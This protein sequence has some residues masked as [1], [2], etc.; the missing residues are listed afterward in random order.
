MN[1]FILLLYVMGWLLF[2]DL[3]TSSYVFNNGASTV[4]SLQVERT[5][6]PFRQAVGIQD[7]S[8]R[9]SG[10]GIHRLWKSSCPLPIGAT[11]TRRQWSQ[12]IHVSHPFLLIL[13]RR[14]EFTLNRVPPG[15]DDTGNGVAVPPSLS[16]VSPTQ[17]EM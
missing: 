11:D 6:R 9:T 13:Y 14:S 4:L 8:A 5:C 2:L 12:V 10:A 7:V 15:R 16:K 3:Y 1:G 17:D